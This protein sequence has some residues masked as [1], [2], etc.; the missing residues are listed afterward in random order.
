M[1]SL[2]NTKGLYGLVAA[3]TYL[4]VTGAYDV[5]SEEKDTASNPEVPP[6][7]TSSS[8][9][10][11]SSTGSVEVDIIPTVLIIDAAK[12]LGG[13]WAQERLYPNLLSQNSYGLYEYSD[14]PLGDAL[15]DSESLEGEDPAGQ[16]IPGWKIHRYL[17]VWCEKWGLLGRMRFGWRVGSLFFFLF[18]SHTLAIFPLL[19]LEGVMMIDRTGREYSSAS[20]R[21]MGSQ[22]YHLS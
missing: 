17:Q 8:S 21:G 3:K 6:V 14:L 1:L 19:F 11:G 22:G 20:H 16:F 10:S 9:S 15:R 4:Q 12:S 13:T 2:T 7:F 5:S 18:H